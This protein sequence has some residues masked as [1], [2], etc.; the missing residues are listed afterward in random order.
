LLIDVISHSSVNP[1]PRVWV[2]QLGKLLQQ[3][4][5]EIRLRVVGLIES[6]RIKELNDQLNLIVQNSNTP[7]GFRLKALGSRLLSDP[8]LSDAEFRMV[9][10]YLAPEN[11]S[12]IRQSAVRLLAPAKL[13]KTQLL[14][15]G[16]E[17]VAQADVFLLPGLVNAF[18]GSTDAE[19]GEALVAALQ[20]SSNRLDN[21]SVSDLEKLF[22]GYPPSVT[23]SAGPLMA[24]LSKRNTARLSQ[25]QAVEAQLKRG[26]VSQ[27]QKL[28]FGKGIC[29]SCHAIADQGGDFGPDLTNIGEIRSRHDILEAI[30]YPGA[31]FAR[32]HE[33]SNVVTKAASYTGIIKEQMAEA[34]IIE[35]APGQR[36]R[37]QRTEITGIEP[38]S[39]SMMPPGLDKLL[40][41]DELSDLMAY[42]ISLPDG[43]GGHGNEH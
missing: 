13:R 34:L 19:V 22:R 18:E 27:G 14:Q 20:S 32:E 36:V 39:T 8:L 4:D 7:P 12:P 21:L 25:L 6:R 33:T 23:K 41:T 15:L 40:T 2:D 16:R 3:G 26:D 38:Q 42:L 5:P 1:I 10:Q 24:T 17:Q 43:M 31:S 9:M 28:F 35:T 11:E 30:L 29:S 37:I